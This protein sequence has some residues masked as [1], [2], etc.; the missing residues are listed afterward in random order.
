[1]GESDNWTFANFSPLPLG[2]EPGVRAQE[3]RLKKGKG[4]FDP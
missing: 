1:M 3:I 4:G 2:E